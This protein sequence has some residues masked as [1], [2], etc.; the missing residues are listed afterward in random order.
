MTHLDKSGGSFVG[1]RKAPWW[2]DMIHAS[3]RE[4]ISLATHAS[5]AH[6][7][8]AWRVTGAAQ[9]GYSEI[10]FTTSFLTPSQTSN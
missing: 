3:Y 1:T 6:P 8:W 9:G 2:N 4:I 10:N 7:S 5:I